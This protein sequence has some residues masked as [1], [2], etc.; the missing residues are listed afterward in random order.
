MIFILLLRFIGICWYN[1]T[2][3]LKYRRKNIENAMYKEKYITRKEQAA[4][5][6]QRIIDTL[7]L[8]VNREDYAKITIREICTKANVSIGTFYLYFNSKEDILID[9]YERADNDLS[10]KMSTT[11]DEVID[12]IKKN[13]NLYITHIVENVGEDLMR[14]V[15]ISSI[16]TGKNFFVNPSRQLYR[17]I[18]ADLSLLHQAGRLKPSL[19]P[20]NICRDIHYFIQMFALQWLTGSDVD[21]GEMQKK[22]SHGLD[23]ALNSFVNV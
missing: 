6:K 22:I 20:D 18:A 19:D 12:N 2:I 10:L 15:Y 4:L 8:L 1:D 3:N 14:S 9:L 5:T 11:A 21:D 23:L 17:T 13:I 7:T 16:N